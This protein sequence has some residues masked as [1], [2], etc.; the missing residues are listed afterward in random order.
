MAF[1]LATFVSVGHPVWSSAVYVNVLEGKQA[2]FS[3]TFFDF[4]L[5][6]PNWVSEKIWI[7]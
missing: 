1:L 6:S 4:L 3:T 2:I 5:V 7:Y